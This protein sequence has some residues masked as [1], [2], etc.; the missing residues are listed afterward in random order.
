[1]SDQ[2]QNQ[3]QSQEIPGLSQEVRNVIQ[4]VKLGPQETM[5]FRCYPGISCFNA[6]CS[7]VDILL[8]PYDMLRL[9]KRLNMSPE[10]FLYQYAN[11]GMLSKGN[12]PVPFLRMDDEKGRCPFNTD[13]GC[14]VY[15]D[16]PVACRYYPIGLGLL[17]PQGETEADA[18]YFLIKE[19]FC[20][21][22]QENKLWTVQEWREDQGSDGYDRMN[23][24]WMELLVKR[25][26]AGDMVRTTT[27][28]SEI[29][30]QASTDPDGFRRFVFNSSFLKR[31]QVNPDVEARIQT[32]DTALLEFAFDW[33]KSVLFSDPLVPARPEAVAELN[34]RKTKEKNHGGGEETRASGG[35]PA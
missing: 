18:F 24:S 22:H 9:R 25:R 14:S 4:P 13:A 15:E 23:R 20:K 8:T 21:G 28:L 12:M 6:C 32:D 17:R 29:F 1:M 10:E 26:S 30:Y 5:R 16:R 3:S 34:A 35:D 27:P 2:D 33:L 7:N 19:D 31:Y 11:P